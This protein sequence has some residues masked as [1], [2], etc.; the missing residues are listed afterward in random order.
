MKCRAIC[1]QSLAA[2]SAT[3]APSSGRRSNVQD[4]R[5][6]RSS[7]KSVLRTGRIRFCKVV[8]LAQVIRWTGRSVTIRLLERATLPDRRLARRPQTPGTTFFQLGPM[9]L[10]RV[11]SG[12]N[13]APSCSSQP[14]SHQK[15]R[16]DRQL[17]WHSMTGR[18]R[19]NY[20][21]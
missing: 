21:A 19:A 10:P 8:T 13:E 5:R 3:P 12:A 18:K 2:G 14:G 16:R 7:L 20:H 15:N 11:E 17:H 6:F 1:K 4:A 9:L